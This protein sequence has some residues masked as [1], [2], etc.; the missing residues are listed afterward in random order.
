M[1]S[2]QIA[3]KLVKTRVQ[4]K[5]RIARHNITRRSDSDTDNAVKVLK[6]FQ[7]NPLLTEQ[8]RVTQIMKIE[9]MPS[10]SQKALNKQPQ[11][12]AN[13]KISEGWSMN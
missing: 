7:V 8:E 4:S 9:E 12:K 13:I 10:F 6:M 3:E 2:N 1:L 5:E 11:I